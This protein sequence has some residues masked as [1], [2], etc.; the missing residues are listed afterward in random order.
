M[1]TRYLY[2]ISDTILKWCACRIGDAVTKRAGGF[3]YEPIKAPNV[4]PIFHSFFENQ[5]ATFADWKRSCTTVKWN[6]HQHQMY[7]SL[8]S[9][10]SFDEELLEKHRNNVGAPYNPDLA[11]TI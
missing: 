4:T 11:P 10:C 6:A 7:D 5:G 8:D 2:T 3:I 1:D 9:L